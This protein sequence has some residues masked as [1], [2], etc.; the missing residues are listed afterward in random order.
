LENIVR[1][2]P[3]NGFSFA[4][5][6]AGS[7]ALERF[8]QEGRFWR[9]IFLKPVLG[10]IAGTDLELGRNQEAK[11]FNGRDC[12]S[13][14]DGMIV[15]HVSLP[16]HRRASIETVNIFD[17]DPRGIIRFPKTASEVTDCTI[18][19]KPAKLATYLATRGN[20]DGK[21][22][23]IGD[24]AGASIN[25]SVRGIDPLSGRVSLYAPVFPDVEYCLAM[26]VSDYETRFAEELDKWAGK[27]VVFSCNCILNYLYGGLEGK[28]TGTLQGPVTFGEIAYL[29]LN[30]TMVVLTIT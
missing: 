28:S 29:L 21:L 13:H 7:V 10:W 14:S 22:P 9:D 27:E 19:G 23:M 20:A 24:F 26:P 8:S 12:S 6:P 16:P 18:D 4:I 2:A 3:D 11:I 5:I 30:Q 15:A 17:R 25:V 1:D